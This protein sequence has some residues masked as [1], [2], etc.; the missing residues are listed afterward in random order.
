MTRLISFM[1]A[2]MAGE[3]AGIGHP[4]MGFFTGVTAAVLFPRVTKVD[5]D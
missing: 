5:V 1:L 2:V 4:I 3:L